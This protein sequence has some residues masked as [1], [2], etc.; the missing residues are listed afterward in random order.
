MNSIDFANDLSQY[1]STLL[2]VPSTKYNNII[3]ILPKR[4]SDGKICYITLNKTRNYLMDLFRKEEIDLNNIVFID[5]ISKSFSN[6]DPPD[7]CYCISSPKALTEL[8][9]AITEF[10]RQNFTYMIFDSLTTLLIYHKDEQPV[11]KFITNI[12]NKIKVYG[13]KGFFY[14]LNINEHSVLIQE[15]SM[16]MDKI[17]DLE[18]E[19]ICNVDLPLHHL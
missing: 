6:V 16:V 10:L 8:S 3:S 7:D 5:A 15:S 14:I 17:I 2:L 9:I 13:C 19:E 12:A 18:N 11:I 1:P 4:L